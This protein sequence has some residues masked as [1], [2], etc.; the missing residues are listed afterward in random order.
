MET[1][2][3][4]LYCPIEENQ[5]VKNIDSV[6]EKKNIFNILLLNSFL[7]DNEITNERT[8]YINQKNKII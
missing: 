7:T 5:G 4:K 6:K 8:K 1:T 2:G 3:A